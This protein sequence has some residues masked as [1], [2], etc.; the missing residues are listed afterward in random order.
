MSADIDWLSRFLAIVTVTGRLEIRCSYGAPWNVTYGDS[1]RGEMPYHLI[2]RGTARL[3]GPNGQGVPLTAG[4]IVLFPHGSAHVLRDGSGLP[5]GPTRERGTPNVLFSENEGQG[6]RL[7]MLCGRFAI[8][9]P[10]DRWL[11]SY[12]PSTL[13]VRAGRE[14]AGDDGL[15][16]A[17]H[18]ANL[19]DLMR[20]E[21]VDGRL[22]GYAMLNA[23]SAALFALVLRVASEAETPPPGLLALAGHPRL[24]PAISAMLDDPARAWTLPELATMCSMSRAT[25]MRH[26]QDGL[27]RSAAELLQDIRMSMAANV[28]KNT[29]DSTEAVAEAVGYQSV[30]AF[31]RVFRESI[32][33]TPGDWRR[34]FRPSVAA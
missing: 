31:R 13:V 27:G 8:A 33:M 18:L 12:L 6:E 29:A 30:S 23:L 32:G 20:S 3:D 24:A 10:H 15:S 14:S 1:S 7:D 28:L 9:A 5:P 34:Q 11:R 2:L 21:S 26:F 25:F 4:D 19:V 17:G 16:A 22:G